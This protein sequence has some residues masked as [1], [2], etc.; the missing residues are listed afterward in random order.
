MKE[1]KYY[2]VEDKKIVKNDGGATVF[3]V[4]EKEIKIDGLRKIFHAFS[5]TEAKKFNDWY[6]FESPNLE[7]DIVLRS[8]DNYYDLKDETR[9]KE[10]F[11]NLVEI[12]S[13][14]IKK[15]LEGKD[16]KALD[17]IMKNCN[18]SVYDVEN[19]VHYLDVSEIK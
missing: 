9:S 2:L 12:I 16:I 17:G 11:T 6:T 8:E 4:Y 15:D 5:F 19:H 14:S 10:E 7:V 18:L 13:F 1:K 3:D